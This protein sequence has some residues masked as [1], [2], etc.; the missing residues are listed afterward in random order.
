MFGDLFCKV[1]T[2]RGKIVISFPIAAP[3]ICFKVNI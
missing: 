3:H 2:D 1:L